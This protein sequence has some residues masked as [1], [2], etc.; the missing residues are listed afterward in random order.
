MLALLLCAS[1][2]ST[3]VVLA[4]VSGLL[5]GIASTSA[6][7]VIRQVIAMS[8]IGLALFYFGA[9]HFATSQFETYASLKEVQL[10]R[11]D[12]ARGA[13]S[14]FE[15]DADVSTT[16]GALRAMPLGIAYLLFAPFPWQLVRCDKR[17]PYLKCSSG[18]RRFRWLI[19]GLTFSLDIGSDRRHRSLSLPCYSHWRIQYFKVTSEQR[20]DSVRNC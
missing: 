12:M 15:K 13:A 8:L 6:K 19:L 5:F 11:T 14:G 20:I 16:A 4:I 7:S 9:T 3:L 17:L 10:R 18:G 1:M 2:S